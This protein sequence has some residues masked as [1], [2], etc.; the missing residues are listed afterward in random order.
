[1]RLLVF[2]QAVDKNDPVLGFFH[3]WLARLAGKFEEITV[4]A[5]RTGESSLP[6]NVKVFSITGDKRKWRIYKIIRLFYLIWITRHSSEAVFV[7]MNKEYVLAG[8]AIWKFYRTPIYLWYN[9]KKADF[10]ARFA[11]RL[12]KKVFYTSPDSAGA[13]MANSVQMPVGVDTELFKP[14]VPIGARGNTLLSLGRIDPVKKIDVLAKAVLI[15]SQDSAL[16][17]QVTIA[18]S[19]SWGN[20]KYSAAIRE[21]LKPLADKGLVRF[22]GGIPHRK[23]AELFNQNKAFINLSPPGLF[24]KT[25]LEA[26]ACGALVISSNPL[27]WEIIGEEGMVAAVEEK[28]IAEKIKASLSL[29][30]TE[31]S[32]RSALNRDFVFKNH[33]LVLWADRLVQE[34]TA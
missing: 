4:I 17:F 33:S 16:N 22:I 8:F 27:V 3:G 6:S 26:M 24:D 11:M 32:R 19:P 7:H 34:I 31:I 5:L 15:L 29:P 1:M 28:K 14:E 2:T 12:A 21:S 10:F 13:K 23:T 9:H 18:G 25:I 20:E 30:Q